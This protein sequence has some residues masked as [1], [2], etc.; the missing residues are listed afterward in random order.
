MLPEAVSKDRLATVIG[1][2]ITLLNVLVL[3]CMIPV[4]QAL[5]WLPRPIN[6]QIGFG[7]AFI[8]SVFSWWHIQR[9]KTP[10]SAPVEVTAQ[11]VQVWRHKPFQRF[12]AMVLAINFSVFMIVSIIQLRL[13][14]GLNAS[15][16]WISVLGMFEMGA[17]ALF[18]FGLSRLIHQFGQRTLIIVG[19]F[20]TFFQPLILAVTPT[21]PPVIIGTVLFG[22]GWF[23]LNVMLYNL[24][25]EIVPSEDLAQYAATYQLLVNVALCCGPFVGT[26]LIENLMSLEAALLL[27]AGLRFVAGILAV[28]TRIKL[29]Q[30]PVAPPVRAAE[31]G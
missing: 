19:T 27:I 18:T 12:A 22:A 4:G 14:R 11:R 1:R 6:Y 26:F 29:E 31:A 3:L 23:G 16:A 10:D 2:R 25:V 15:D 5:E 8:A 30:E 28:V 9:I 7:L 13:V 24:L 21:L 17:G 20:A